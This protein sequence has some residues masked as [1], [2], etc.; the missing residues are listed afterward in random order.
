MSKPKTIYISFADSKFQASQQRVKRDIELGNIFDETRLFTMDWLAKTDFYLENKNI[1]EQER[2]AGWCLWKPYIILEN[3]EKLQ[4]NEILIYMDVGDQPYKGISEFV[5]NW[6]KDN[7]ILITTG[8][9]C[10]K[11]YAKRDVFV[12]MECDSEQY[13]NAPQV[14]AGFIALK[15]NDFCV[16]LV[17]EWL[18][19]CKDE[20][21]ITDIPNQGGHENFEEF[22]DFRADQSVLSIL[23]VKYSIKTTNEFA[24]GDKPENCL[25]RWNV[26]NPLMLGGV[27]RLNPAFSSM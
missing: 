7:E 8:G 17:R 1:L 5:I 11:S 22:I 18:E 3:L 15:K 25:V 19:Y 9:N 12:F 2:Y 10:N 23:A 24:R 14:E 26:N 27:T 13:W 21:I 20:R 16:N 4:D 6:M